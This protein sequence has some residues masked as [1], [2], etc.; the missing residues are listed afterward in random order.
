L[1]FSD[2][3]KAPA[4]AVKVSASAADIVRAT[5]SGTPEVFARL[6]GPSLIGFSIYLVVETAAASIASGNSL[7]R[8]VLEVTRDVLLLPFDIAIYRLL[9][10]REITSQYRFA[11]FDTRFQRLLK[12]TIGLWLVTSLPP[13]VVN[14]LNSSEAINGIASAIFLV[15]S[16][17]FTIRLVILFPAIAVDANGA[18]LESTLADTRGRSW[19]IVKAFCIVFVPLLLATIVVAELAWRGIISDALDLS[20]WSTFPRIVFVATIGFLTTTASVVM[21]ARLFDWIGHR[22]LGAPASGAG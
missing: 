21:T 15:M 3:S 16:V 5:S 10:L 7:L 19:L 17:A 18:T 12:W 13:D 4:L 6:R 8:D 11:I 20:H 14:L 2:Q 9:I 1:N 22:V